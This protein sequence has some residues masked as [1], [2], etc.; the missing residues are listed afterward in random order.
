MTFLRSAAPTENA[1]VLDV[2]SGASYKLVMIAEDNVGNMRPAFA[3]APSI[4]VFFPLAEGK[5]SL[6]DTR[7]E[8]IAEIERNYRYLCNIYFL[9]LTILCWCSHPVFVIV[10]ICDMVGKNS[11]SLN[12]KI[13]T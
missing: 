2:P 12:K 13:I 5:D 1:V 3:G 6:E 10:I 4:N 11:F 7:N 9:P 8:S